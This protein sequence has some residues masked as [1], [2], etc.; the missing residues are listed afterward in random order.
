MADKHGSI[1]AIGGIEV[2]DVMGRVGSAQFK[3]NARLIA[4]APELLAALENA[5]D[6]LA[7]AE[8]NASGNPEWDHVGPRVAAVRAAIAKARAVA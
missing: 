4:A 6:I 2:C 8:S 5:M 3:A 1:F 7:R